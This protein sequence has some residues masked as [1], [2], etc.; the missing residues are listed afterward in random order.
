MA[1]EEITQQNTSK[2]RKRLKKCQITFEVSEFSIGGS[3]LKPALWF[4]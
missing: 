3:V 4:P 1:N 2:A